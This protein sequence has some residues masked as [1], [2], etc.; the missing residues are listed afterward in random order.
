[1][2]GITGSGKSTLLDLTMG[3]LQPSEGAILIDGVSLDRYEKRR[4]WQGHIAHVPQSIFLSATT[5]AENI[6][7]GVPKDKIDLEKVK[8]CAQ[9]A[10]ISDTIANWPKGYNT[11]VGE[12]GIRLSGGQ[13]QRI[14]IA[15]A[16]YKDVDVLILDEA[17]SALDEQTEAEV[18]EAI[19][20][21]NP[22]LTIIM[23]AH[24]LSTLERCDEI[25][26]LHGQQIHKTTPIVQG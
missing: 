19:H 17:T 2:K 20:R 21:L 25:L 14:G 10:Q 12:R 1:M 9:M 13:R 4:G 3:L 24:R 6:A 8:R 23:V 7:F 22:E 16:L 11:Q 15:R 26:E 18:M 5:I